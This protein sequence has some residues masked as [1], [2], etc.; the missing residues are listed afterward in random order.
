M[1]KQIQIMTLLI[2]M[3]NGFC[4]FDIYGQESSAQTAP[5]SFYIVKNPLPSEYIKMYVIDSVSKWQQKGRFE[6]TEQYRARVNET[7][8]QQL[9]DR[10]TAIAAGNFLKEYKKENLQDLTVTMGDYDADNQTW[11]VTTSLF[12]Q[13][14]LPVPLTAAPQFEHSYKV[15]KDI[16]ELY[17]DGEDVKLKKMPFISQGQT[18]WY[19]N[20]QAA[21]FASANINITFDPIE[22][23]LP[24]ANASGNK[25]NITTKSIT[26][27]TQKSDVELNIP[28]T[29]AVNAKT[30]VVIIANENYD[31]EA[32][33]PFAK[34]DGTLFKEYCTKTL[35]IPEKNIRLREDA[36]LNHIRATINW[37]SETLKSYNGEAKAIV[38][39]SGHGIPDE[40]TGTAYL[41]PVDG[42]GKDYKTGMNMA[43]MYKQ[44]GDAG[45]K[46]VTYF[47]DACF[48]GA[49]K[50][51]GMLASARGIAVKVKEDVMPGNSILFSAATGDET[52]YAYNEKGHGMF[53]Y[54]LL[55]KLQETK[56]NV[57]YLDLMDYVTSKVRQ[58][59]I[60]ENSKSQTPTVVPNAQLGDVWKTWTLK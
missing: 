11:L 6:P 1:S 55:K 25:Q 8:R 13:L 56:G 10:L 43:E 50:E 24:V 29:S 3:V 31:F 54:F 26:L 41:L 32:S 4:I 33:V 20:S 40:A 45:G 30:F 17:L 28:T 52:A 39:Y 19:D 42:S 35:G 48:S 37:L 27:G 57:S 12:G 16:I 18:F 38:Y 21:T 49:K 2:V 44:L 22:V 9:A 23:D 15:D 59:S 47:I 53:T 46:S 34:A 51:G 36:T 14:V 58:T 7:S 5:Q 60:V